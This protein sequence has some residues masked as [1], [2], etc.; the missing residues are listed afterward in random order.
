MDKQKVVVAIYI[1]LYYDKPLCRS[2]NNSTMKID[3][4]YNGH[5]ALFL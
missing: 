2:L 5:R 1:F 4:A 3:T